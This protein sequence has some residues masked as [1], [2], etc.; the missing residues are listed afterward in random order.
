MSKLAERHRRIEQ[1]R[2]LRL[3]LES[4]LGLGNRFRDELIGIR[5]AQVDAEI[6]RVE[7]RVRW[8]LDNKKPPGCEPGGFRAGFGW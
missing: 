3:Q 4:R 6:A 2:N 8:G 7:G 5:I 1:L